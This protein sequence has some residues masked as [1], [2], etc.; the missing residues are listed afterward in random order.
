[1][2][3][4]YS[5]IGRENGY[6][7]KLIIILTDYIESSKLKST[8]VTKIMQMNIV[9]TISDYNKLNWIYGDL[10]LNFKHLTK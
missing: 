10:K 2:Q 6:S 5:A 8:Y 1:M 7:V 4:K 9:Q 3:L